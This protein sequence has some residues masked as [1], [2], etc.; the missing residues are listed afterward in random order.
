[1]PFPAFSGSDAPWTHERSSAPVRVIRGRTPDDERAY[2]EGKIDLI[3]GDTRLS[4]DEKSR[5][6]EQLRQQL[7]KKPPPNAPDRHE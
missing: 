2:I 6:I 5:A 1:V 7:P 4:D 3:K